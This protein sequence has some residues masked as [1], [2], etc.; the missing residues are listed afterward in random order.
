MI[1]NRVWDQIRVA[2]HSS[3]DATRTQV[4]R[5]RTSSQHIRDLWIG[6]SLHPLNAAFS[7]ILKK[8]NII[9][10]ELSVDLSSALK[11]KRLSI[12]HLQSSV[13]YSHINS[14]DKSRNLTLIPSLKQKRRQSH[15][16]SGL[17]YQSSRRRKN[18][19]FRSSVRVS[20][21]RNCSLRH[22]V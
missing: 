22:A 21:C 4:R 14:W 1:L 7:S 5:I 12:F 3:V 2:C 6:V 10:I 8:M 13:T 11:D 20:P 17:T 15:A 19:D 18:M 9:Q 16:S